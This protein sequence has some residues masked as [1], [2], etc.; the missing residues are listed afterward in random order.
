MIKKP[1]I[2]SILT[3]FMW[4]TGI[5][6]TIFVLHNP[7]FHY[8]GLPLWGVHSCSIFITRCYCNNYCHCKM[9]KIQTQMAKILI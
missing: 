7:D 5:K 4:Y 9:G 2:L 6:G 1:I 3:L 8:N